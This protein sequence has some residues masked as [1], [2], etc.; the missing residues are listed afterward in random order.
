MIIWGSQD[1]FL[2]LLPSTC[3]GFDPCTFFTVTAF[4]LLK[5]KLHFTVQSSCK[6]QKCLNCECKC[7]LF[8]TSVPFFIAGEQN[9]RVR[10]ARFQLS[11]LQSSAF[12]KKEKI[13]PVFCEDTKDLTSAHMQFEFIKHNNNGERKDK[14]TQIR[15]KN[16]RILLS[17]NV[18]GNNLT[19]LL[20]VTRRVV[21][22]ANAWSY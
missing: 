14:A 8:T 10:L 16:G 13:P 17:W 5:R 3:S 9:C 1:Y 21:L 15:S 7:R 18:L 4:I 12:I 6:R 20:T 22:A 2:L 11:R 19:C